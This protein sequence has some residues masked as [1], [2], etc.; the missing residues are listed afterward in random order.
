MNEPRLNLAD[1]VWVKPYQCW[2]KITKIEWQEKI[3]L[4]GD[5]NISAGFVYWVELERKDLKPKGFSR[6]C[7][8]E[9]LV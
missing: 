2:G 8:S 7:L 9:K 5:R 4:E 3:I 6:S 1:R